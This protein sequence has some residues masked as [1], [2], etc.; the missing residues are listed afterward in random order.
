LPYQENL[1]LNRAVLYAMSGMLKSGAKHCSLKTQELLLYL[2]SGYAQM[3]E[4]LRFVL[5]GAKLLKKLSQ[6]AT[7]PA[8]PLEISAQNDV[9]EIKRAV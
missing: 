4:S 2:L 6:N 1:N 5:G 3:R 9:C 8:L 7:P